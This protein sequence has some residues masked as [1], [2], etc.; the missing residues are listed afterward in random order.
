MR[1][2]L[3]LTLR[4]NLKNELSYLGSATESIKVECERLGHILPTAMQSSLTSESVQNT[5]DKGRRT[6]KMNKK[7]SVSGHSDDVEMMVTD[8][9]VV[10]STV[11][12]A[13]KCGSMRRLDYQEKG[14]RQG[15]D[16]VRMR[17]CAVILKKLMTHRDGWV[18]NHP[19]DPV[20][21]KIPDYFSIISE[22]MDLGTIKCKL[23]TKLYSDAREFASDVRL[24]FSN[25]MQYNPPGNGVHSMAKE[26]NN[27]FNS[28]WKSLEAK[29]IEESMTLQ[30]PNLK[31]T[32]K[33]THESRQ[34]VP[35][36]PA[37][38]L[39]SLSRRSLTSE[40]KQKL[41]KDLAK[42]SH[43]N[44][45][46]HLLNFLERFSSLGRT[47]G[48]I[49]VDIDAFDEETAW[50]LY[51]IIR[52]C[53]EAKSAKCPDV[54]SSPGYSSL[55][56]D[57][58]KGNSGDNRFKHGNGNGN[59]L[60]SPATC[61]N[62]TGDDMSCCR[63]HTDFTQ[64]SSSDLDSDRSLDKENH[65]VD[66]PACNKTTTSTR[67]GNSDPDSDGAAS[68]VEEENFE[69][70][71]CPDPSY[72]E[73]LSPNKAL[74]AA[75]LRSRFADTILKAQNKTL[76]NHGEKGDPIRMQREREKL[77]KKQL[78]EKA[79]I[80]AQVRAAEAAAR[81]KAEAELKMRREREREAARLALQKMEKTVEIDENREIMKDLEMLGF[82]L[83]NHYVD[84]VASATH[85][86]NPLEQLGL[87]MKNEDMEDDED[88]VWNCDV[89]EG[90]IDCSS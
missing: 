3:K 5:L 66:R 39:K 68:V 74:R 89:E 30:R 17:Q 44:M 38:C 15:M 32:P 53:I 62:D 41:R 22:P 24:T 26:L 70:S 16:G 29:W 49:E 47:N 71:S 78:E 11:S 63:L 51:R 4:K 31:K 60:K 10:R 46:P 54:K 56:K 42:L 77:E 12:N 33:R 37:S 34:I 13:N 8:K 82:S 73:Q 75:M 72:D 6:L 69:P 2:P 80:E 48:R 27:I 40:D 18:F 14:K 52:S 55:R 83:P 21:L 76:L 20:Q 19:V 67:R 25:A 64:A 35:K 57:L 36:T 81:S 43:G 87:F 79:R 50:E 1:A 45:P 58:L 59:S 7:Y 9:T 88:A 61:V 23:E 90:E 85:C 28:R 84:M 86:G 65:Q